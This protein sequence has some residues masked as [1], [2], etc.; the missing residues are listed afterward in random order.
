M[1]QTLLQQKYARLAK[2]SKLIARSRCR[3][4]GRDILHSQLARYEWLIELANGVPGP[5]S[6]LR[7]H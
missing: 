6:S 7:L 1:A 4:S 3:E 5:Y 2:Q